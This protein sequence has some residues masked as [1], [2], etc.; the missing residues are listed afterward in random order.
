METKI[1]LPSNLNRVGRR[2]RKYTS[3]RDL[4]FP[5]D[6]RGELRYKQGMNLAVPESR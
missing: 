3:V 5:F 1:S 2:V 6:F 4:S